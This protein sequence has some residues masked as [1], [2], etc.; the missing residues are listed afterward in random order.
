MGRSC[1]SGCDRRVFPKALW[2]ECSVEARFSRTGGTPNSPPSAAQTAGSPR[3]RMKIRASP[4]VP[5]ADPAPVCPPGGMGGGAVGSVSLAESQRD[6]ESQR[7]APHR[8]WPREAR[9]LCARSERGDHRAW[10]RADPAQFLARLHFVPLQILTR[11]QS[12]RT[13]LRQTTAIVRARVT[14]HALRRL[15]VEVD[16]LRIRR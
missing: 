8:D 7:R 6:C 10:S 15:V 11:S 13:V 12:L 4:S 16:P 3:L 9:V 1:A 2:I 14:N 5:R